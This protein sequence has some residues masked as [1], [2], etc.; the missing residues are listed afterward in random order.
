MYIFLSI[1]I[2]LILVNLFITYR[3]I[4][5][6]NKILANTIKEHLNNE[7]KTL[8]NNITEYLNTI[9]ENS[10]KQQQD[11][12]KTIV[13][14]TTNLTKG[15]KESL[16]KLN[17]TID[18]KLKDLKENNKKELQ[19][20]RQ[21]VDEKLQSTLEKRLGDSFRMISE[22]LEKLY[23][24]L[25][26]I[27][28]LATDVG[29]LQRT[30][31]N[32]KIR[33]TWGEVQLGN[34]LEQ[35]LSTEQFEKNA[36]VNP[37]SQNIVE[38]AVIMPGKNNRILLPIDAKFPQEDYQKL[39]D[40]SEKN[41]IIEIQK[42]KKNLLDTIKKEAKTISEKYIYPPNTTNFAI[43]FLPTE[44]LYSEAL[45][46]H[47][48]F[49]KLQQDYKIT[50]A[51]PTT[52]IAILNSL[53]MGFKTLAIEKKS[54]QVWQ[55]LEEVKTEFNKFSDTLQKVKRQLETASK[56]LDETDTRTRAVN[57]K[58]DKIEQLPNKN[59]DINL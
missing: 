22:R 34:I 15:N 9:S 4:D 7:N 38:Y 8:A 36:R 1:I 53:S 26:S 13:E 25:G 12:N 30:L 3:L 23:E 6:K 14:L 31:T 48:L 29:N 55:I 10:F 56:S 54:S 42:A 37:Q 41:N 44:G 49:E 16:D 45:R 52:L 20:I 57:R 40:A 19:E 27:Q 58:L 11:N 39:V 47:G 51:G 59:T 32:V 50:I 43:M 2:L 46:E 21:I 35:F 28:N 5:S 18:N 24:G 17:E 33:G